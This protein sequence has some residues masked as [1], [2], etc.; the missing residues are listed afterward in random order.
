LQYR[1]FFPGDGHYRAVAE[2]MGAIAVHLGL[3]PRRRAFKAAG[4]LKELNKLASAARGEQN[5]LSRCSGVLLAHM[6]FFVNP[7]RLRLDPRKVWRLGPGLPRP[8]AWT[9]GRL[10]ARIVAPEVALRADSGAVVRMARRGEVLPLAQVEGMRFTPASPRGHGLRQ[11]PRI[12]I[13]ANVRAQL[14]GGR[15]WIAQQ[16][17]PAFELVGA[18][19]ER[20]CYSGAALT[21]RHHSWDGHGAAAKAL[22]ASLQL[23]NGTARCHDDDRRRNGPHTC[24][25]HSAPRR[26]AD[27]AAFGGVVCAGW[28]DLYHVP[29]ALLADFAELMGLYVRHTVFHEVAVP[30][31]LNILSN[32]SANEEVISFC[33]G[34][35]CCDLDAG[36]AAAPILESHACAHRVD[37]RSEAVRS[38]MAAV[39]L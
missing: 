24:T 32:G 19:V 30:T 10:S 15:E 36:A 25:R 39:L 13:A 37:L 29:R 12:R 1:E 6:D 14:S 27:W 22:G 17:P 20:R 5:A 26:T 7:A 21:S 23:A 18:F 38:A 35:C 28:S 33:W 34:C 4:W 8:G 11:P 3:A 31:I 9:E 2:T 16:S